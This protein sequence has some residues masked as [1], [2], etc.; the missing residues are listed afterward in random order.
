MWTRG[1]KRTPSFPSKRVNTSEAAIPVLEDVGFI[2]ISFTER[3]EKKAPKSGKAAKHAAENPH[4]RPIVCRRWADIPEAE[5]PPGLVVEEEFLSETE[6][7]DIVDYLD[8]Q[9]WDDSI[10]RRTQ[11]YGRK[12]NYENLHC[13]DTGGAE[14][15]LPKELVPPQL[16]T[17]R[18]DDGLQPFL[19]DQCTV[20]EY[21]PGTGISPHVET[22]SCFEEGFCS[23]SLLSG[24]S[25]ELVYAGD[26]S[27]VDVKDDDHRKLTK[28]SEGARVCSIWL[29]ARSRIT[30]TGESRYAWKHGI[31]KRSTDSL[32]NSAS[33]AGT[34]STL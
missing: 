22:H 10:K 18:D 9:P 7:R 6:E 26:L 20:N 4:S 23:I 1:G 25:M 8:A 17:V 16:S 3:V 28:T 14:N 32:Q 5:R 27:N 29:P 11:H 13:D 33:P 12:F 21:L 19:Y 15:L 30:F 31:A 2:N 24:I 34:P